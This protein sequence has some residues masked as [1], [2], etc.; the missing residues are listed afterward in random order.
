MKLDSV[1]CEIEFLPLVYPS[2]D[3]D[4][5]SLAARVHAVV[6]AKYRPFHPGMN[7]GEAE[8]ADGNLSPV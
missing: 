8:Q 6:S 1:S 2:P 4:R 5:T 7:A 3:E